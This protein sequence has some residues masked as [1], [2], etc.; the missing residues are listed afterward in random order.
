MR[1]HA[2]SRGM[3]RRRMLGIGGA[4][5]LM[6]TAGL[7]VSAALAR[8]PSM[9]GA[10]L[11]SAVPLPAP[12]QVQLPIPAVLKPVSTSGGTDRYE[13]IQREVSA[14][15]LPGIKTPLWTYAGTFPGPTIESRAA[16]RS[17]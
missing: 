8:R 16:D 4:L 2:G 17:P 11:R 9:T 1:E 6:A 14:E 7:S 13:M 15:I 10:Q 12:F 5:G 3:S